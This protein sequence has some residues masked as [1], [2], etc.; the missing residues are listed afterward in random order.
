MSSNGLVSMSISNSVTEIEASTFQN[1][2][3][4]TS[5]TVPNSV[6]KIGN[7]AFSGCTGLTSITIPNSVL[8]IGKSAFE[9]CA[10]ELIINSRVLERDYTSS[11]ANLFTD[12]L[13][14]KVSI[15]DNITKLGNYVFYHLTNLTEVEMSNS[16]TSIGDYTF[17]NLSNM[18]NITIPSSICSIG[19]NAF[20]GCTRL[21]SVNITDL[22]AWCMITFATQVS[23]PIAINGAKLSLNGVE[24]TELIIP[25]DITKIN[26]YAFY[27][28][29]GLT[30]ITLPE[31][32]VSI[33]R[34]A[35]M[36]CNVTEIYCK[37]P[38]PASVETEIFSKNRP[39]YV[40]TASVEAYK[41]AEGWSDYASYI[42]GY[43]F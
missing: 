6:T 15:G 12:A 31:S 2:S 13:F 1:C 17:A 42:V 23:N 26:K 29:S 7:Y 33:G 37:S 41:T 24:I 19:S 35:F 3:S 8:T 39:I 9:K 28:C 36:Y 40:P 27:K 10:G 21:T 43:D 38:T 11:S 22:S 4:L 18:E 34:R 32:I 14:T 16:I 20:S 5:I 25:S 30:S